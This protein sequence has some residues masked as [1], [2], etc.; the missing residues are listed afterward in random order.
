MAE[1]SAQEAHPIR[2]CASAIPSTSE[3]KNETQNIVSIDIADANPFTR[4]SKELETKAIG[5]KR[6]FTAT[7]LA[8]SKKDRDCLVESE[9]VRRR[10]VYVERIARDLCNLRRDHTQRFPFE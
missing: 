4:S 3:V 7:H 5:G 2:T 10:L 8:L 1:E 6:S 9:Q